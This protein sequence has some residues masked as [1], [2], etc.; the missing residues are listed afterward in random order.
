ALIFLGKHENVDAIIEARFVIQHCTGIRSLDIPVTVFF[1]RP[2]E[3]GDIESLFVKYHVAINAYKVVAEGLVQNAL[4]VDRIGFHFP[5]SGNPFFF[6]ADTE[7][8]T[9]FIL[10]ASAE[11]QHKGSDE[12]EAK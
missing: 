3:P 7:H 11:R 9:V 5:L 10:V 1:K 12:Q 6:G 4:P 2:N 8:G